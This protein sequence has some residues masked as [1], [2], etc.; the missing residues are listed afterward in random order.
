[1]GLGSAI[2]AA[3]NR[4]TMSIN[5]IWVLKTNPQ[6]LKPEK[7]QA[8][9][10]ALAGHPVTTRRTTAAKTCPVERVAIVILVENTIESVIAFLDLAG[11]F[12]PNDVFGLN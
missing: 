1:M 11:K 7:A 2:A 4:K 8:R 12:I 3:D 5:V 10:D 9:Q 6:I